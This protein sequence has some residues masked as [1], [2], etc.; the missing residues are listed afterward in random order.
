M[1]FNNF[2]AICF[3]NDLETMVAICGVITTKREAMSNRDNLIYIHEIINNSNIGWPY[4]FFFTFKIKP[5][6]WAGAV[7][8]TI[9]GGKNKLPLN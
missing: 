7:L 5:H 2:H 8:L 9:L 1:F 6:D 3:I 4:F